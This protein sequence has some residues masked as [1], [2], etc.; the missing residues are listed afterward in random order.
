MVSGRICP[1]RQSLWGE[2]FPVRAAIAQ[3]VGEDVAASCADLIR[4]VGLKICWQGGLV[5]LCMFIGVIA[6]AVAN[7]WT[8]GKR[9]NDMTMLCSLLVTIY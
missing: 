5:G 3:G 6:V 8:L 2:G 7:A 4:L 9:E 1:G